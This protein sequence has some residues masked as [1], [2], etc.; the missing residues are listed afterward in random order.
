MDNSKRSPDG[1]QGPARLPYEPP[2]IVEEEVFERQALQACD[3]TPEDG[4]ACDD[5][6]AGKSPNIS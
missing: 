4:A 3:K 2:A 1:G 6:F 5:A